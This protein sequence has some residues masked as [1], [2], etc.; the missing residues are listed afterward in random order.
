G[1]IIFL[2][3][4]LQNN[5]EEIKE[6]IGYVPDEVTL[7][8]FLKVE[9]FINFIIESNLLNSQLLQER[10]N[11]LDKKLC[12]FEY[13]NHL[14]KDLS[15]GTKQRI[16]IFAAL[17]KK[18]KM[19]VVDEPL[20]GLDPF[21]INNVKELFREYTNMERGSILM[22]THL[23]NIAE[24]LSTKICIILG[25]KIY[26]TGT[27]EDLKNKYDTNTSLETLFLKILELNPD[28]YKI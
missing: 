22:S 18:P 27:I 6:H 26:Y 12:I 17:L 1:E 28:T 10:I 21:F 13:K 14:I 20:V 5:F 4:N 11:Y 25:G 15:L 24:E 8:D 16:G 2:D 19:L 23:L 7:Y 9:E 3:K